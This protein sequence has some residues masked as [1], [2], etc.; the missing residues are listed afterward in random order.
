MGKV[1]RGAPFFAIYYCGET[2]T[3]EYFFYEKL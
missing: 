3:K 1:A 2:P